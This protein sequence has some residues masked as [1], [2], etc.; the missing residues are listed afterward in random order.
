MTIGLICAIPEEL[1]HLQDLLDDAT[2]TT[3][4]HAEFREGLLA[5][6]RVV[7]AGAGMGKVNAAIV[8]TVLAERFRCDAV[9]LSGVAG[10]LDPTLDIGDVVIADHIVQHDCG[11]IEN[12]TLLSYQ[13]GHVSF[14]NPTGQLGYQTDAELLARVTACL[15][16]VEL[17]VIPRAAGGRDRPPR[18]TAG[19]ILTGDQYIHCEATRGQLHEK[20]G[21]SAVEME[22]GAVAQVCETFGIPWLVIRALSDLAGRDSSIDFPLFVDRVASISATVL[23]RIL[24]AIR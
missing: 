5:G 4:G 1:A 3:I 21:A 8:T 19:T 13:P 23:C 16:G 22:G 15:D 24:P 17:P 18:I 7:L 10:G 12:E 6:R 14:I 11:R 9:V 20:F 2:P